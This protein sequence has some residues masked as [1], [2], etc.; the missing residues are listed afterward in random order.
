MT[1]RKHLTAVAR[2]TTL[3]GSAI[4]LAPAAGAASYPY[5][6][7]SQL[8]SN[9]AGVVLH[10]YGDEF[11]IW[12]NVN[13]GTAVY[14]RYNYK[15]VSDSWKN[16]GTVYGGS[17]ATFSHNMYESI[18][19]KKAYIYFEVCRIYETPRPRTVCSSAAYYRT[20]GS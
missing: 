13:D 3:L 7:W 9:T 5:Q 18:N 1:I 16:V 6:N 10:P 11:E 14:A 4:A 15:D 2:A 17:H 20:W 8:P 12:N 19:G